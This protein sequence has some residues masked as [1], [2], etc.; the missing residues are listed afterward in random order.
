MFGLSAPEVAAFLM[1]NWKFPL[2]MCAAVRHHLEPMRT[3]GV[4]IE[5]Y[6]LNLAGW[7]ATKLGK[8]LPGESGCWQLFPAKLQQAGVTEEVLQECAE[9]TEIALHQIKNTL[10]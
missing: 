3:P 5:A 4:P 8:G 7:V 6:W 1:E 10:R 2:S 9:A